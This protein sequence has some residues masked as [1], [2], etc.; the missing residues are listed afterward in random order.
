MTKGMKSSEFYAS[1][2]GVIAGV[3]GHFGL[4]IPADV[5]MAIMSPVITFIISR[6]MAKHEPRG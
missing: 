2:A 1:V 4:D 5:I 6:G 3:V